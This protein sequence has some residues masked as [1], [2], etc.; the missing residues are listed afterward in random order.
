[1]RLLAVFE[2]L[3]KYSVNLEK[4]EI[5]SQDKNINI[6]LKNCLSSLKKLTDLR[7]DSKAP[8]EKERLEIIRDNVAKLTNLYVAEDVFGVTREIFKE[9][10]HI[11]INII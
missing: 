9:R 6:V 11:S 5:R 4:F 2:K 3:Y 10:K 7:L 8:R 1:M